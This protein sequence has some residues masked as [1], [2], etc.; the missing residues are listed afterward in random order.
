MSKNYQKALIDKLNLIYGY[1][2][3]V[4]PEDQKT[5]NYRIQFSIINNRV[6]IRLDTTGEPLHKRGYRPVTHEAPLRETLAAAILM[7]SFYKRNIKNGEVLYDPFC[8]SGTFLIEAALIA[9]NT[10]PGIQR[11]FAGEDYRII[12][13]RA[14]DRVRELAKNKSLI[15]N[16]DLLEKLNYVILNLI[17]LHRKLQHIFIRV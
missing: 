11:H 17:K 14:F 8:G 4:V 13:R 16:S 1:P 10:A 2:N 12:G 15:Y 5:G 7:V 3:D 9:S 6:K